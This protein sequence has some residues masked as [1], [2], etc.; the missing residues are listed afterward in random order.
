MVLLKDN[1]KIVKKFCSRCKTT[2]GE[3]MVNS[4][5]GNK[6]YYYCRDCN[7]TRCAK[8][9]ATPNGKERIFRAVKESI[10]RHPEK[11]I[12]RV[13]LNQAVTKGDVEK[14][15]KCKCGQNK[16]EAHHSD[17]SQ[18]LKVQWLCRGCHSNAHRLSTKT[19]V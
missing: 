4:R 19:V 11:Q 17:Y 9:R 15:K 5:S 1:M 14:P 8:Y 6:T 2:E 18:P 12:A 7:T 10:E 16:P 3:F 13:I